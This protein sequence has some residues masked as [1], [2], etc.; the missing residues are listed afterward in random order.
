MYRVIDKFVDLQDNNYGYRPGDEFP[1]K[2]GS[3][4]EA[5]LK[6]LASANNKQHRPLIEYVADEKPAVTT[7]EPP[8]DA[9]AE[10]PAEKPAEKKSTSTRKKKG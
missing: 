7:P 1:R 2:G 6:E 8:T 9:P 3:A 10:A 4:S 5:R